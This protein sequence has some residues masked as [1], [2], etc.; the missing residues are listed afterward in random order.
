ML[1]ESVT[2]TTFVLQYEEIDTTGTYAEHLN[3]R[4][5][6]E[7]VVIYIDVATMHQD[8]KASSL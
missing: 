7:N 8:P 3:T 4:G 5:M 1:V 2:A 6:S